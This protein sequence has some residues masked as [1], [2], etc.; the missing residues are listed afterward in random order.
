MN[1][2][3]LTGKE[4]RLIDNAFR[5]F[6][7][8]FDDDIYSKIMMEILL[9]EL[10]GKPIPVSGKPEQRRCEDT[11]PDEGELPTYSID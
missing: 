6:T 5:K 10:Y 1:N 8:Q 2:R 7:D 4:I 11:D 9:E 3:E